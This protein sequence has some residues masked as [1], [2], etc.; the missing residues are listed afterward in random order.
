MTK[1]KKQPK[2]NKS[3]EFLSKLSCQD[4]I[5]LDFFS[6]D[7]EGNTNIV[8]DRSKLHEVIAKLGS[9]GC[10]WLISGHIKQGIELKPYCFELAEIIS[11][12]G[13]ILRNIIT[14]FIPNTLEAQYRLTPRYAHILFFVK[15]RNKY[16]FNKDLVREKHIWK[17]VEWGKRSGRYN[18]LGK[19][20]SNIWLLTD[21][22]GRGNK[23][24]H[25]PLSIT[26]VINRMRL[27]SVPQ[28][29]N[30][31]IY[32]D[33]PLNINQA[34]ILPTNELINTCAISTTKTNA[35][36]AKR[37]QET[38][39]K[40]SLVY[41]VFQRSS[42][43]MNTLKDGQVNLIVTSPPYWD[44][45]NY[46]VKDQ[47]G[48]SES[49]DAYLLRIKRVWTECYRVLND[50]GTFWLNINTKTHNKEIRMIHNDFIKQ[51]ID[52]GFKLWDIIIWHKSVSGPAPNN[53]LTDKF[54]YVLA[55]YKSPGFYFNKDYE[56]TK[57]DYLIPHMETMGN[58]WN[59]NRF[60]GSIGKSFPHPA[61]YP[62]ELIE[63]ILNFGTVVGD[64][65]LD[66][67]LGSGTTLIVAKKLSRSCIG[68]EINSDYFAILKKRL[69][70]EKLENLFNVNEKV[71]FT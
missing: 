13:L 58:M 22:D 60:W 55:F 29:G 17:G 49:Y 35:T 42:E 71:M 68:Y 32:S 34:T 56:H 40:D 16:Y 61:M 57:N 3:N 48:Y 52:I 9:I 7:P 39:T 67:F 54:E 19:D 64:L 59:I 10:L 21:D 38:H 41:R 18:S 66:P 44:M 43:N 33:S 30:L 63:R 26:D 46:E 23:T 53:N 4:T 25:I 14:W 6:C 36:N 45:K 62:D 51:C 20:P 28:N 2:V 8:V 47:I 15:D 5:I 31:T 11:E 69:Y 24:K 65:V 50:K 37:E 27:L 1:A 12:E 70:D